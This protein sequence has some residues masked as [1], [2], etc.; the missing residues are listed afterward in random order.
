VSGSALIGLPAPAVTSELVWLSQTLETSPVP[1][2]ALVVGSDPVLSPDGT[3]VAFV[4]DAESDRHLVVRDLKTGSDARLTPVGQDAPTLD[5]PSWFPLGDEV[6]FTIGSTTSRKIVA[7]RTDG[8]GGQ[9]MLVSGLSGQVT[10]DRRY[11]VFLVDEGVATRLRYAPLLA[12]G[13]VGA[14]ERVLKQS[15]P[16]IRNFDLSSDGSTLAYS[17]QEADGKLNAFLTDFPA[18]SRQLQVTTSG[19]AHPRF[20]GDGKA[21]FYLAPATPQTDPPR[22]AVAERPITLKPLDTSGPPVQLFIEGKAPL[23]WL[24]PLFDVWRDGRL[25][26][27]RRT[28]G[29]KRPSPRLI[30]VQNWRAAVGR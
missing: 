20:S 12:D 24:V 23:D 6:V 9:R 16:Y 18:G 19:G 10:P 17:L 26:T 14:A 4:V 21:L 11:L 8:A 22:G 15:D 29:D 25:L 27:L 2:T 1:G 30:L 3:R 5:A 28:G 13:S 7:R